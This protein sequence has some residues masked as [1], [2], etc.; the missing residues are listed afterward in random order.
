MGVISKNL[1]CR[2]TNKERTV[3]ECEG[4]GRQFDPYVWC[5]LHDRIN[6]D[7]YGRSTFNYDAGKPYDDKN[8]RSHQAIQAFKDEHEKCEV[9]SATTYVSESGVTVI[10]RRRT[11]G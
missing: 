6:N 9:R 8:N 5:I 3:L 1:P 4:C 10:D 7:P 11:V 2:V